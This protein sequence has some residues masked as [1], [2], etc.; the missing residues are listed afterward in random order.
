ML[1]IKRSIMTTTTFGTDERDFG[2]ERNFNVTMNILGNFNA[3]KCRATFGGSIDRGKLWY[4][5]LTF[6]YHSSHTVFDFQNHSY[7]C[8]V[9][10]YF[11]YIKVFVYIKY[12]LCYN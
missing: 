9:V 7:F 3:Q 6:I 12:K 2:F 1:T 4:Y 8:R 11:S 10:F 5:K